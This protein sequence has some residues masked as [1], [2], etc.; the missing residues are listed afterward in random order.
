MQVFLALVLQFS[1]GTCCP[2][3]M[4][5]LLEIEEVINPQKAANERATWS[6][7]SHY[8]GDQLSLMAAVRDL[9][10]S[11]EKDYF[12]DLSWINIK[13]LNSLIWTNQSFHYFTYLKGIIRLDEERQRF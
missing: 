8:Y 2:L 6:L 3:L 9:R 4:L 10:Y 12:R 13:E 5:M 11:L 7:F 1:L